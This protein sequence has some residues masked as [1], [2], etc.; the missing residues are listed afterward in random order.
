MKKA[1]DDYKKKNIF[2]QLPTS[3]EQWKLIKS[4]INS[5][6]QIEK[7]DKLGE[8]SHFV[9]DDRKIA[10]IF[11]NCSARLGLYKGKEVSPNH[12]SLTFE[13]PEFS[14]RP[15]TRKEM[16]N[17]IDNLS[18]HNSP[19]PGYIP[20]WALK[21]SKLS[22]STHL[23]FVVNE[24]MNKNTFLNILKTA[25]VTPVYKKVDRLEPENYRPISVKPTVAK[26]LERLLLEQLT[27]RRTLNGLLN[28]NQF[29]FQK[30]KSC[31]DTIISL[32]EKINQCVDENEIVVTPFSDL[33]KA[34]NSI[35]LDVFMNNIK[36]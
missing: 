7:I 26:N 27:H 11:N 19:G 18:E 8:G 30:Q 10:N 29:G 21:D 35:S 12:S 24:C 22:I 15:V 13:E 28:K 33:A 23:Q 16:Y 32:T 5:N 14:F 31:L 20:A 2:Q 9:E 3:R 4:R 17:V 1:T 25:H 6:S 36:R 34:F